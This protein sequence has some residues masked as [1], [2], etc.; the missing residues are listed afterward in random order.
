MTKVLCFGLNNLR[1]DNLWQIP[2]TPQK[3]IGSR[4]DVLYCLRNIYYQKSWDRI[5]LPELSGLV[6]LKYNNYF[7]AAC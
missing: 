3:I 2:S 7:T 1:I 6:V 4:V 5:I